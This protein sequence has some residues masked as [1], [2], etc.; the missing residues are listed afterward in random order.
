MGSNLGVGVSTQN[1]K[2]RTSQINF[3][4]DVPLGNH[5][6][7]TRIVLVRVVLMSSYKVL[8]MK[9]PRNIKLDYVCIAEGSH[10]SAF[11]RLRTPSPRVWGS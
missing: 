2:C 6:T 7:D 3:F 8:M 1:I 9:S 10:P 11:P 5:T 4:V